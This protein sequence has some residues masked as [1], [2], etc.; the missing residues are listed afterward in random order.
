[1]LQQAVHKSELSYLLGR[2]EEESFP[3]VIMEVEGFPHLET[4]KYQP[5]LLF[6]CLCVKQAGKQTAEMLQV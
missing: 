3:Q 5:T 2:L 1:M 4:T 6:F